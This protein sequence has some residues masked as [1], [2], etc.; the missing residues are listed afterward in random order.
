MFL[1]LRRSQDKGDIAEVA[2]GNREKDCQE[3]V[4][5]IVT[6]YNGEMMSWLC[7]AYHQCR[8]DKSSQNA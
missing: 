5:N 8:Y 3:N 1:D 2:I 7:V 4:K 6:D